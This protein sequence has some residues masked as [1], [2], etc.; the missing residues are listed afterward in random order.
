M[1][2]IWRGGAASLCAQELS[3]CGEE[4]R[5]LYLFDTFE[6]KWPIPTLVDSTIY[7]RSNEATHSFVHR[8]IELSHKQDAV[9]NAGVSREHVIKLLHSTK[10]P[11]SLFHLVEGYV[12][13]T[14][15]ESIPKDTSLALVH[16]D[17]DFYQS[18]LHELKSLYPQ[19]VKG[20]V[21]IIDDVPT[22]R[23]ADQAVEEYFN[24]I[25]FKPFMSRLDYQGR[26]I[27]KP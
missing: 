1:T 9:S 25:K 17:T 12:E 26:L 5:H 20:G 19:I 15:P 10:Y 27:I 24:G 22:E 21:L 7:G 3:R 18:T 4:T 6:W 8:Q 23:G 16:L 11:Q 14:L 13:N 2:G